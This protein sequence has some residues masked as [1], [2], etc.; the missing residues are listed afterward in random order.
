MSENKTFQCP[1]CGSPLTVQG[2]EKETK[3]PYC[4]S[5]VI[6][7]EELRTKPAPTPVSFPTPATIP[8]NDDPI[9]KDISTVGKVATGIALSTMIAPIVITVV[10]LCVVGVFL[11]FL[12]W[13][14]N[15]TV[16]TTSQAANPSALQTEIVSTLLPVDTDTPIPPPTAAPTPI[17]LATPFKR[18]LVHDTFATKKNDWNQSSDSNYTLGYVK[19]GYRIFI[20]AQDGGQASWID[21]NFK[22]L[23]VE[24]DVKYVAGPGDGRF[25]LICRAQDKVGFYG[26]EFSNDGSYSI[27]KYDKD[28]NSAALAEGSLDPSGIDMSAVHLR[29]DCVGHTLTLYVNG[30]PLL[31]V[32]DQS[33]TS[34]GVG[35]IARTGP[36]GDPGV[37]ILFSNYSALGK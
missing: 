24:V 25:G 10:V 8:Q 31:Q 2:S 26:F 16:Q 6:V 4:G 15:S 29:G 35:M 34:G 36:S 13:G 30:N 20:N 14:I 9:A 17:P 21:G 5:T 22:E 32:S 23:N 33:F 37:D 11:G 12:F 7:P 27:E 3:C 1:N 28:G 19:G 18:V